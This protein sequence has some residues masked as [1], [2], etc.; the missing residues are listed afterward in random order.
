MFFVDG[1]HEGGCWGEDF[2]DEDEDSF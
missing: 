1:G 2:V